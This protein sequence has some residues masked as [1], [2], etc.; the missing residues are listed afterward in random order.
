M[1]CNDIDSN[2]HLQLLRVFITFLVKKIIGR[3]FYTASTVNL[4]RLQVSRF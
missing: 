3:I 2:F 4:T 1:T